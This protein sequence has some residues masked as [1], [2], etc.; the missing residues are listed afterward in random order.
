MQSVNNNIQVQINREIN[1]LNAKNRE[2]MLFIYYSIFKTLQYQISNLGI[3][4]RA[5]RNL[6]ED[7]FTSLKMRSRP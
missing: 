6:F 1:E 5:V 7:K 2:R 4:M 3:D